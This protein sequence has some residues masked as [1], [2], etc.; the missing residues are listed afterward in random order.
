MKVN[1]LK[2]LLFSNYLL[3][4]NPDNLVKRCVNNLEYNFG[5]I[6]II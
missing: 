1:N 3:L 6:G 2:K 4:T 5:R